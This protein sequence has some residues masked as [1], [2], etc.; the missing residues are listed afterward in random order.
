GYTD[1]DPDRAW[2]V[3]DWAKRAA[4]GAMFD[5][6]TLNAILPAVD[7]D[8]SHTGLDR[9]DRAT[10][11]EIRE[12]ATQMEAIVQKLDSADGGLNPLGLA[13]G[14]VPFDID[15]AFL[16]IG[17]G[18]Q[19]Q[20]HF[21]QILQRAQDALGNTLK[22]F[23][24]VNGMSHSIRAG[25]DSTAAFAREVA[26]QEQDFK[27]R[28]IEAFGY[29]YPGE[30][31]PGKLYPSGYDGPDLTHYMYVN[32]AEINP[33]MAQASAQLEGFFK[34][35]N[36]SDTN[37]GVS[38]DADVNSLRED[39]SSSYSTSTKNVIGV[40]YPL[41][42]GSWLFE[43]PADWGQRRAP[44]ELQIVLSD[45]VQADARLK[46][47]I[48]NY[49][50]LIWEIKSPMYSMGSEYNS[51]ADME[52]EVLNKSAQ[53][54]KD[55]VK[56]LAGMESARTALDR[57]GT[58]I[59]EL[60]SG[61]IE[62][63]P[64][65]VGMSTDATA[66]ARGGLKTAAYIAKFGSDVA[67]DGLGIAMTGLQADQE[68]DGINQEIKLKTLESQYEMRQTMNEMVTKLRQEPALRLEMHTQ[69]EVV[70]QTLGRYRVALASGQRL[71]EER[72]A[73]RRKTAGDA[74][75][76]RYRDMAYRIFRNDA[77]QKYRA[78]F[79]L[80]A[81]YA[82]LAAAAYDYESNLIGNDGKAGRRFFTDIVR[83]RAL[84][85]IVDGVP[86]A[87]QYGLADPL[88]R[89]AAN[90]AVMKTQMGF[91]NPQSAYSLC[92]SDFQVGFCLP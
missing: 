8:P 59:T 12:V 7:P 10:V 67:S 71:I 54:K 34:F 39:L 56:A 89:M 3:D 6:F 28:L 85:A 46:Q 24:E 62:G 63:M 75:K 26:E 86:I 31:G 69:K 65:V 49:D 19:G 27:N 14:V 51:Y 11:P 82:Y 53:K 50:E 16:V 52:L 15:P 80:A 74:T 58:A 42:A 91:N 60:A 41:S 57:V 44:G 76:V 79:D 66:P 30:M 47:A 78:S 2:G 25:E 37:A 87:S 73:F 43:A 77:I 20:G 38:L 84:G 17:S 83:Q 68:I 61:L 33:G 55:V 32:T 40:N 45:L 5:W 29:P 13:K 18:N 23:N 36:D 64:K 92:S 70:E 22:V 21:E 1:T 48:K 9:I 90:Y 81:R 35:L 72:N 88:A 4:H